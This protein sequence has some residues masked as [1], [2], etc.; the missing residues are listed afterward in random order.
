[1]GIINAKE[2]EEHAE[3]KCWAYSALSY[4]YNEQ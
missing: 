3:W 1:M 2:N 4:L